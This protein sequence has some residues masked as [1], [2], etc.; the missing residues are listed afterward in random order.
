MVYVSPPYW[1]M[2]IRNSYR[3]I[4]L[5]ALEVVQASGV[6]CESLHRSHNFVLSL[7][8]LRRRLLLLH[9]FIASDDTGELG[10][11]TYDSE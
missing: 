4:P 9:I 3:H 10:E 5:K 11:I 6:V 8:N 7:H 2:S 1:Y